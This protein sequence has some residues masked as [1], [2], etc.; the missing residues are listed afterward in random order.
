MKTIR[1]VDISLR[2][3]YDF[4]PLFLTSVGFCP[5]KIILLHWSLKFSKFLFSALYLTP[6]FFFVKCKLSLPIIDN[7]VAIQIVTV[8]ASFVDVCSQNRVPPTI[9]IIYEFN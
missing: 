7:V 6:L 2:V 9:E 8:N 1:V 5:S 3:K 4:G